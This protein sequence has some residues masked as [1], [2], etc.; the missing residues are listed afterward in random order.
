MMSSIACDASDANPE[1]GNDKTLLRRA[2]LAVRRSLD[3]VTRQEW[4]AKLDQRVI[5]WT[6][7]WR[8]TNPHSL[9]GVY[10]PIRGEPDLRRTYA[11]LA[12]SSLQLALPVMFGNHMPLRFVA[13]IPGEAMQKDSFGV[14]IPASDVAVSPTALL[15][16]CV[17]F[18][19]HRIRLGY[20]G[21]FYDR[22]LAAEPH[23]Q[24]IGI[25]YSCGLAEFA[26]A[27]H[28]IAL[29]AIITETGEL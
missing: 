23:P 10:W 4:D 28:D 8:K 3:G 17:G 1:S 5:E 27:E 7:Q 2:L 18:N 21:G 29:D 20:G 16:P 6:T 26:G 22:T 11:T 14:S 24:T 19:R 9:L 13:W 12:A 25:A 15:I